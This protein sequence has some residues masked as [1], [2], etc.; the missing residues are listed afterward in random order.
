[1]GPLAAERL[2]PLLGPA[3]EGPPALEEAPELQEASELLEPPALLWAPELQEAP[4]D[5]GL[6]PPSLSECDPVGVGPSA[7]LQLAEA[8]ARLSLQGLGWGLA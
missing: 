3:L 6:A 7:R 1:M 2:L 4:S 5:S 8:A